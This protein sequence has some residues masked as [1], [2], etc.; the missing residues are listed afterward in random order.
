MTRRLD[1]GSLARLASAGGE[2]IYY[3]AGAQ[4]LTSTHS[5]VLSPAG[6]PRHEEPLLQ[7][8]AC[9]SGRLAPRFKSLPRCVAC[10][11]ALKVEY[12]ECRFQG[13]N[14]MLWLDLRGSGNGE[15]RN[16]RSK[17]DGWR[18]VVPARRSAARTNRLP[19]AEPETGRQGQ[20]HHTG[21]RH[22]F[23][24]FGTWVTM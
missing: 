15:D 16:A 9:K 24:I 21:E 5:C 2:G 17:R 10:A 7:K 19:Y 8:E 13:K 14:N 11:G 3:S 22:L 12:T 6:M 1:V 20:S 18:G 4:S 23:N